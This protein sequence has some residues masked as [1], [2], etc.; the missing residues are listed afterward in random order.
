MTLHI[1]AIIHDAQALGAQT[2]TLFITRRA[3]C[4]QT[5]TA[6]SGKNPMPGQARAFRELAKRSPNPPCSSTQTS[7]FGKLAVGHHITCGH[8]HQG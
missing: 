4:W 3:T 2:R 7:Q 6:T 1:Y 5:D 8:H